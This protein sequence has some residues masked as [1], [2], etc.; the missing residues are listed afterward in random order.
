MGLGPIIYYMWFLGLGTFSVIAKS[1]L[2]AVSSFGRDDEPS[3]SIKSSSIGV[4][5]GSG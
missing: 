2:G 3:V 4:E 5:L 1:S